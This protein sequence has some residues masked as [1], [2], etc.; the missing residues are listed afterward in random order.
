M[1]AGRVA[2]VV[3]MVIALIGNHAMAVEEPAFRSVLQAGPFEIRDYPA[4]VVAEVTV[5]GGQRE[6]ANRGFRLLAKYIF[7]GNARGQGIAMTAPVAQSRVDDGVVRDGV[8]RPGATGGWIVRFT[9]PSG[10]ALETLPAPN[11]PQ[12][13]LT[14]LP[15]ERMAVRR[16]SG[17]AF[18]G[19]VATERRALLDEVEARH[20]SI[21]GAVTLAQYNPPWT[22]WFLRRNEVMVPIGPVP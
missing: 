12:V 4:L 6:A 15:A 7:G 16:F 2:L 9:M 14:R 1:R 22:L 20:L 5:P 21:R 8:V 17:L 13:R 3:C 11:D 19:D 10:F 18:E